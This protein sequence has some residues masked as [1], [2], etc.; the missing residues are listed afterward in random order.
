[1]II[2]CV[3]IIDK[4]AGELQTTS[5][6]LTIGK[7]YSVLAVEND[8][9]S[10]LL[11]RVMSDDGFTPILAD[12]REFKLV[13]SRLSATWI[14]SLDRNGNLML[15]PKAWTR[16]GFWEEYFD[17]EPE[18]MKQFEQARKA[19]EAE[20]GDFAEAAPPGMQS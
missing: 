5:H 6:W 3:K 19:I 17:R 14:G 11:F 16:P 15:A 10:G 20:V 2:E 12:W 8:G 7:S 13:S 9:E 4:L 18:A 1:M